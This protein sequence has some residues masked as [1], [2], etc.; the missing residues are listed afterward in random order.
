MLNQLNERVGQFIAAREMDRISDPDLRVARHLAALFHPQLYPRVG[1]YL[2]ITQQELG[3]L[4]GLSRQRV[5]QALNHLASQQLIRVE[6]GGVRVLD[7]NG[8]RSF[9]A[10][11]LLKQPSP[12]R[13]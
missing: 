5:N 10:V 3:Y 1:E 8:L 4:V 2:R 9:P 11:P 12:L 6:Y 7:L 13:G